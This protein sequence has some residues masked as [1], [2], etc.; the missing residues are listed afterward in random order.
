VH[1]KPKQERINFN[2]TDDELGHVRNPVNS[3]SLSAAIQSGES[4]VIQTPQITMNISEK[5]SHVI[6][7]FC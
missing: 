6:T 3:G 7:S 1:E 4:G 2:I 5:S